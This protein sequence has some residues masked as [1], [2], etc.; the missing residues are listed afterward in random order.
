M[1]R[2]HRI[3]RR[4]YDTDFYLKKK[5]KEETLFTPSEPA[6]LAVKYE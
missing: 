2:S 6:I 3:A 1:P 4:K 5:K